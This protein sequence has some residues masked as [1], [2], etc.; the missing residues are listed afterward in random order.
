MVDLH[1]LYPN[2]DVQYLQRGLLRASM[3]AIDPTHARPDAIRHAFNRRAPLTPGKV[4]EIKLSLPPIG[5]VIREGHRL[6]V[7]IMAPSPIAQPDW[8][9]HPAGQPGRNTVY[10]SATQPSVLTIPVIPGAKAQGPAPVC[11]SLDFQPCR[12]ANTIDALMYIVRRRSCRA[13]RSR[14]R[15]PRVVLSPVHSAPARTRTSP[16]WTPH[17]ALTMSLGRRRPGAP[18]APE[19]DMTTAGQ[20]DCRASAHTTRQR[21]H[22]NAH[23]LQADRAKQRCRS[24][25]S[26]AEGTRYRHR[27][28]R[29]RGV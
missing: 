15:G 28:R 25:S 18:N 14:C 17:G 19:R 16:A 5:A 20:P 12:A 27:P 21:L 13:V 8:G 1:D 9:V 10:N 7:T 3:R 6:E 4:Y 24:S 22:A 23:G 29:N 11:G 2:G 26:L